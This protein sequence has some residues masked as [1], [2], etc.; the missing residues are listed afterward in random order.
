MTM[1]RRAGRILVAVVAL[2]IVVSVAGVLAGPIYGSQSSRRPWLSQ[3][4]GGPVIVTF[5]SAPPQKSWIMEAKLIFTE[6]SGLVLRF[7][8]ERDKFFSYGNIISVDPK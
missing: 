7:P 6:A 2:A 5:V 3:F 4:E 1:S 8:K